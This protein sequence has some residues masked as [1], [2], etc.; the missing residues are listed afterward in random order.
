MKV[1]VVLSCITLAIARPEA[2]YSYNQPSFSA[3]S[4]GLNT[5]S[6]GKL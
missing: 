6:F 4:V 3:P 5:P 2:G 1:L